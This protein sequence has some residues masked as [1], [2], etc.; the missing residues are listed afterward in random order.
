MSPRIV[1]F[2]NLFPS[3]ARPTHGRFVF[4]HS[5]SNKKSKVEVCRGQT[6]VTVVDLTSGK[7]YKELPGEVWERYRALT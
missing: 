3:A 7:L 1:T 6:A 5:I 2:S 4:D